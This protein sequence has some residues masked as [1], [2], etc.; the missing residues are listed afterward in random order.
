MCPEDS[1]GGGAD[2]SDPAGPGVHGSRWEAAIQAGPDSMMR[3]EDTTITP[4]QGRRGDPTPLRDLAKP[5]GDD[6][7][8]DAHAGTAEIVIRSRP[9][10]IGIDWK[11]MIAYRDLFF[12]LVWR[13]ISVR[14]KQTVLGPAWAIL[15]P[16]LLMLI[17][18]L[19]F[20]RG[21]L[22][23]DT[24]GLEPYPVFVFAGL[25]PWALFS[26]GMPQA[27]LSLVSQQNLLTKVYFPRLFVPVAAACVFLVDLVISLGIYALLLLGFGVVPSWTV[28]FL[29][30]L[31]V[32][33]LIATL[34][35]GVLISALT[36]FYRDFRH[37][38]PFLVQIFLFVTPVIYPATALSRRYQWV[39]ALNPMF[40]VVP[41]YRSA[42]LG[43]P[44]D[45]LNL[46]ISAASGL[47]LFVLAVFYFRR[48]ERH[49]ADVA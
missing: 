7:H 12:Y 8:A 37:V 18:T 35:V 3:T 26:Q 41:A 5:A 40:G 49:F 15:Q 33:T 31:I 10:W 14:Y 24:G 27:A 28:I 16:L 21:G 11:E 4:P 6:A 19:F 36:V 43:R 38:V 2:E 30:A 20:G 23:I 29:P 45:F 17:F 42:I 1:I 25:I 22:K 39:L 47:G 44:W 13:D 34:G 9:G 32:L 46:G 48:M